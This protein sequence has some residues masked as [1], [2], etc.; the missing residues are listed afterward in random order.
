MFFQIK[1]KTQLFCCVITQ[2]GLHVFKKPPKTVLLITQQPDHSEEPLVYPLCKEDGKTALICTFMCLQSVQR[3]CTPT[4]PVS[5]LL[6][7]YVASCTLD[8]RTTQTYRQLCPGLSRN[9]ACSSPS[10]EFCKYDKVP[11]DAWMTSTEPEEL[12]IHE[13]ARIGVNN[14]E[15][16]KSRC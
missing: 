5:M 3:H 2:L 13:V 8:L 4:K 11:S 7:S 14:I 1:K 9:Q 12:S 16:S 15:Y 10:T 6:R